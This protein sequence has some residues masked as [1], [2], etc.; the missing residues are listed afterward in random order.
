MGLSNAGFAASWID[1]SYLGPEVACV[2]DRHLSVASIDTAIAGESTPIELE[3]G[4]VIEDNENLVLG[5]P[6][7]VSRNH[8]PADLLADDFIDTVFHGMGHSIASVIHGRHTFEAVAEDL[9]TI[10]GECC[11]TKLRLALYA[12]EV[13][14]N[15][16]QWSHC[17]NRTHLRHPSD[18]R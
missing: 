11:E 6:P 3:V 9:L 4:S 17:R 18:L 12:I 2:I 16:Y 1:L 14:T 10:R 15:K 5:L 13:A 8:D 7:L